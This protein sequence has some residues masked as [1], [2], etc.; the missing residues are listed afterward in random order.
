METSEQPAATEQH[1]PVPSVE[2]PPASGHERLIRSVVNW[3]IDIDP[4]RRRAV[5]DAVADLR[6]M[7]YNGSRGVPP[8]DPP[9]NS[10]AAA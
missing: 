9:E 1:A 2:L 10:N 5:I 3:T 6:A 4:A 8:P 7:L